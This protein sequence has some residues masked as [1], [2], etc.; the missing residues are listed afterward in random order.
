MGLLAKAGGLEEVPDGQMSILAVTLDQAD[1]PERVH[2]P[3]RAFLL[4][5]EPAHGAGLQ[6]GIGRAADMDQILAVFVQALEIEAAGVLAAFQETF[7]LRDGFVHARIV[8]LGEADWK[9]QRQGQAFVLVIAAAHPFC[10]QRIGQLQIRRGV[11]LH[12]SIG[13]ALEGWRV[14]FQPVDNLPPGGQ[15]CQEQQRAEKK[16]ET[17]EHQ[18][19]IWTERRA[20]PCGEPEESPRQNAPSR[21]RSGGCRPR[22]VPR[23]KKPSRRRDP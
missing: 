2:L 23:P 7:Q 5:G 9:F 20:G 14:H 1:D 10:I 22:T 12:A 11:L 3:E 13:I 21:D 8:P 19:I 18:A 16:T 17:H 6:H 15:S 4:L